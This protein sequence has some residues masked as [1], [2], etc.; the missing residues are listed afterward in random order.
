M[1]ALLLHALAAHAATAPHLTPPPQYLAAQVITNNNGLTSGKATIQIQAV[2]PAFFPASDGKHVAATHADG[3]GVLP[4]GTGRSTPAKPGETIAL[5]GN[6][7]GPTN[8]AIPNGM[9]VTVDSPLV[10]PPTITIGGTPAQVTFAG[11]TAAGVYQFNV[12]VPATTPDGDIPVVAQLGALTTQ[13]NI[14]IPVQH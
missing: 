7:F 8:P 9:M 11:L 14:T 1:P 10:N 5:F 6:G 12:M 2:A 3:S 4:A 13:S